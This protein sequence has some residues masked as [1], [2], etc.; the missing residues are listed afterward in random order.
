VFLSVCSFSWQ[1]THTSPKEFNYKLNDKP[2][3]LCYDIINRRT[4]PKT[5]KGDRTMKAM[6]TANFYECELQAI[7]QA[8][9]YSYYE[10]RPYQDKQRQVG[11]S[12]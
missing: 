10:V 9:E 5:R 4:Q 3:K 1:L 12:V 6:I 2:Q 8:E 11:L 7:F